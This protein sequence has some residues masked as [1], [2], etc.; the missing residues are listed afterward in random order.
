MSD[1][2]LVQLANMYIKQRIMLAVPAGQNKVPSKFHLGPVKGGSDWSNGF[3]VLKFDHLQFL[4]ERESSKSIL[5]Q[6]G[7]VIDF[8]YCK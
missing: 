3:R 8:T 5:F 7:G 1:I 4:D 6:E 2:D